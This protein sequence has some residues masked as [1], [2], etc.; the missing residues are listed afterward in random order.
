V[1][2]WA[3]LLA[4]AAPLTWFTSSRPMSDVPGLVLATIAQVLLL[5]AWRRENQPAPPAPGPERRPS[6][7]A[8]AVCGALAAGLAL[9]VRSQVLW[10][11]V[12]LM[13]AVIV[14]RGRRLGVRAVLPGIGAYALGIA[15]W[16]IPLIVATGGW[17]R[18]IGALQ[19]Q[20]GEDFAGV[21]MLWTHFGFRRLL[22]GLGQTFVLPWSSVPLALVVLLLALAGLAWMLRHARLSLVLLGLL[23]LPY[24]AFHLLFQETVTTRY[25]LPL[26]PAVC[27]L[28]ARGAAT[29]RIA[30]GACALLVVWS[31]AVA[32]PALRAYASRPSPI[33]QAIGDMTAQ[34]A[35]RHSL[36]VLAM[37]R[38]V[39]T[40]ARPAIQW[41]KGIT[42]WSRRLPSPRGTEWA[43]AAQVLRRHP[44]TT[45]WFLGEP[46][47]SGELRF[48][49]LALIDPDARASVRQYRWGFDSTG[50]LDGA[51]PDTMD[52]YEISP[53]GWIAGK[54]WALTPETAGLAARDKAG[55]TYQPI[56]ALVR[57]RAQATVLVLGGRHLGTA[58]D[59]PARLEVSVDG[60]LT[61]ELA[62]P[63]S[64]RFFLA[65]RSLPAGT[66]AGTGPFATL[67][68]RARPSAGSGRA[69]P[70]AVEQFDLQD[71]DETVYGYAAGW[72][73]AEYDPSEQ[74]MWRWMSERATVR[75][76]AGTARSMTLDITGESP[77]KYFDRPAE[78]RV[79]VG[80]TELAR[81]VPEARLPR[82]L[83][84]VTGGVFTLSLPLRADQLAAAGGEVTFEADQ[85]FVPAAEAQ[86]ADRRHLSLRIFD[87]AIHEERD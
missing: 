80:R 62:V 58:A 26:V 21:D 10:L 55:P 83:A 29:R 39:A 1:A 57:R 73:E 75:V 9:G 61:T 82:L 20:G 44:D 86:N 65:I 40:E 15:A 60:R 36:P 27:Y 32:L 72:Q 50:L 54:G 69:V 84:R 6:A 85:F 5:V 43:E 49:D 51:R 19:A 7:N 74:R 71:A 33:F 56:E 8:W 81:L 48:R 67:A 34:S 52:L 76:H 70:L 14:A 47:R 87:L 66:F 30:N 64:P 41:V 4:A 35:R 68:V 24:A 11:T 13:V 16:A 53:P 3:A 42:A 79:R 63:A 28:A 22:V 77:R 25:A 78:F 59:G 23:A 37:H 18:Y 17:W 38:R 45:V 46:A 31:L 12:P 2:V